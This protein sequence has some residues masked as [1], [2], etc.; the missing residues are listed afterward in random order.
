M[1]LKHLALAITAA[2]AVSSAQAAIVDI[3][4]T[5][6]AYGTVFSTQIPYVSFSLQGTGS[7]AGSP[8]INGTSWS[9]KGLSNSASGEY[10]TASI[11]DIKFDG[12]ANNVKFKFDNYGSSSSG[13]GHTFYTAFNQ[14]GTAI[15]TGF[16]G[17]GGS[18]SLA[19]TGIAGLQFN[20]GTTGSNNW[21]FAVNTL[22]ANVAPVPEPETYALMGMGLLGLMA[23]RRRKA[24]QA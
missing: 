22:Q 8:V 16:V 13:R 10:P 14:L 6:Y 20:N 7:T 21:L 5:N 15:E 11:L 1:K 24:K 19:A 23:A 17:A 18:F 12:L 3:D 2:L 9:G 4:F